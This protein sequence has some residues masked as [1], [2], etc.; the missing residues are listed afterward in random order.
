MKENNSV[1]LIGAGVMAEDYTKVLKAMEIP[2]EVIGRSES[3]AE[4]FL[5]NTEVK[6]HVGGLSNFLTKQTTPAKYAIVSVSREE[7]ASAT[8][9]LLAFGVKNILVEKPVALNK[10]EL[11]NLF[12]YDCSNVVVAFNRRYYASTKKAKEI[13]ERDGG[14]KSFHFEFTEW[15]HHLGEELKTKGKNVSETWC[16]GNSVHVFDTAFYLGGVPKELQCF[17]AGKNEIDWHPNASIFSGSGISEKGALFSYHANWTSPG[18]WG[19]EILTDNYRL[20][21]KPM[22][23]LSIQKKGTI[24]SEKIE[25]EDQIDKNFKPGLYRQV[26]SFLDLNFENF[27]QLYEYKDIFSDYMKIAG[28]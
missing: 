4:R 24:H 15:A 22:E 28:Y 27:C 10:S 5:K 11:D 21:L 25:I 1:W 2:F 18:R 8:K 17:H 26:E 14:V 7:L 12:D 20:Y 13:I 6:S 19:V 9:K 3:T 16:L 23:E